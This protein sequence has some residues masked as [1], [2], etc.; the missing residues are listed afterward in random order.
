MFFKK[1]LKLVLCTLTLFTTITMHPMGPNELID[2]LTKNG[3]TVSLK[4]K[5]AEQSGTISHLL[6]DV[7]DQAQ[8]AI[9]LPISTA[10]FKSIKPLLKK[11]FKSSRLPQPDTQLSQQ[12]L[13]Q[14]YTQLSQKI[15]QQQSDNT[16][17]K[18]IQTT[19]Y[20]DCPP[21]LEKCADVLAERTFKKN[22]NLYIVSAFVWTQKMLQKLPN[23]LLVLIQQA[24]LKKSCDLFEHVHN[25][26]Q[27]EIKPITLTDN[28]GQIRSVHYDIDGKNII[29]QIDDDTICHWDPETQQKTTLINKTHW[30]SLASRN[31]NRIHSNKIYFETSA[32]SPDGSTYA[33]GGSDTVCIWDL[34]KKELL[35]HKKLPRQ[36]R[37]MCMSYHPALTRL[38]VGSG[39]R[40]EVVIFDIETMDVIHTL[41]T[42]GI[43][44]KN[45]K[46]APDGRTLATSNIGRSNSVKI[47]DQELENCLKTI[48][49]GDDSDDTFGPPVICY[50]PNNQF[51]ACAAS[52]KITIYETTNNYACIKDIKRGEKPLNNDK[53]INLI[54]YTSDGKYLI[55]GLQ[56][57]TIE[58]RETNNY[59]CI[60]TLSYDRPIWS[61]A[62]NKNGSHMASISPGKEYPESRLVLW[63]ISSLFLENIFK[64]LNFEELLL[65]TKVALAK[66]NSTKLEVC[67]LHTNE[68]DATTGIKISDIYANIPSQLKEKLEPYIRLNR[69]CKCTFLP[70]K[71]PGTPKT[72][73][74]NNYDF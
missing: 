68:L 71:V 40:G 58:F 28:N 29:T 51:L 6:G 44:V 60:K 13:Q 65:I 8:E 73:E 67:P 53:Q 34:N 30:P 69:S 43:W 25:P 20:L 64:E 1:A 61:V 55:A 57:G 54:Q 27:T 9:P 36:F 22:S 47:W 12:N 37:T 48:D 63:D 32:Y 50:S 46:Y 10:M 52:N 38:A 56:D 72:T 39:P 42:N 31:E 14:Q 74:R 2:F 3:D 70:I 24:Y 11:N 18:L 21:I 7:D 49:V 35:N 59:T 23:E 33:I 5:I 15:L 17:L 66:K 16:L 26:M 19:N 41:K 62:F 45:I 4:R